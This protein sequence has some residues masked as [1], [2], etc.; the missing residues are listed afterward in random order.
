MPDSIQ[1][2]RKFLIRKATVEDAAAIINVH[3]QA[4]HTTA[5]RDYDAGTLN[6]WSSNATDERIDQMKSQLN[7]NPDHTIMIVAELDDFV[8][9]FGEIVP[10][11]NELRAVYVLP[12]T[13]RMGIGKKRSASS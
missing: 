3:Y 2:Q 10:G 5:A 7:L 9:G 1:P 12:T 4:V 13:S 11:N 8:V 6:E